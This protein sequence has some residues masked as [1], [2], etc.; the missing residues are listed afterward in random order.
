[1]RPSALLVPC[2][3]LA[4]CNA[5]PDDAT[6]AGRDE[7][8][9]AALDE[10]TSPGHVHSLHNPAHDPS[11]AK[12]KSSNLVDHGGAVLATSTTYAIYWGTQS[13]FSPDLQTGMDALLSGLGGSSYLGIGQQYM[14]GAPISTVFGGDFA[15]TSLPPK[16]APNSAALGAE[17]CKLF[18]A[19]DPNGI[20]VV[21]TS[22]APNINYCAWHNKTTCNGVT[23]QVA[24]VPN[25]ELLPN[26]S[27][28]TVSN[29]NCNGYSAGTVTAADSVAH[30][31]MEAI[32]DPHI[33]AWYD[34]NRLEVA[35][36]CE[37][38]YAAC[39]ALPNGSSWQIQQ[40]WSNALGGCQQQ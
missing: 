11:T 1:M 8:T 25:Q 17:V 2:L 38:N 22:N 9:S 12:T 15:D 10:S 16:S 6:L 39:V 24:Y 28:L 40:E 29:L 3:L 21:F 33:D 23:F 4:G 26:C 7:T 13:A 35:D 31:V 19:P 34:A 36:K 37:Y 32:T 5:Q 18:P 20:Y 27:P 14:R 30:E